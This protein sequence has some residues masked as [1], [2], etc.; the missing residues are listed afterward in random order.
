MKITYHGHSCFTIE[1]NG[2]S[3]VTDPYAEVDGI[4]MP[5]LTANAVYCSHE[6]FDHNYRDGV[7][8]VDGVGSGMFVS[9]MHV[10]H[11]DQEG[12][13]RGR[14]DVMIFSAEGKKAVHMGDIGHDLPDEMI[15]ALGHVDVLMIPVGGFFTIDAYQAVSFVR[16]INP[17]IVIPMHY[18]DGKIGFDKI[19]TVEDFVSLLTTEEQKK[20]RLVKGY[21]E[22]IE[23]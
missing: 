17:D 16:R 1:S 9:L 8:I 14:N 5:K 21:G 6:H 20:L 2:Y 10:F 22:S 7:E 4:E 15:A 13:L 3:V 19:A 11:D 23:L 18:R 12:A